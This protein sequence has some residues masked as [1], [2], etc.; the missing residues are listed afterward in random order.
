[1]RLALLLC[2][3]AQFAGAQDAASAYSSRVQPLLKTYCTEC[4]AV[5]APG[6]SE[7][8]RPVTILVQAPAD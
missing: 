6:A 5:N 8:S 2:L 4:H 1:M 7:L 3:L